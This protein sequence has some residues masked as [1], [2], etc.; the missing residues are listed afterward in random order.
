[1]GFRVLL[2]LIVA[3]TL[4]LGA[5]PASTQAQDA[6]PEATLDLPAW[7]QTW[8]ATQETEDIHAFTD[9]YTH[10]AT[11]EIIGDNVAVHDSLSIREVAGM[12]AAAVKD[13]DLVPTTFHAG[14]DWAV[15][16]YTM[17]F[18]A[19]LAGGKPVRDVR[20]VTVFDLDDAGLITRSTDYFN[21]LAI[22]TQLGRMLVDS[23]PTP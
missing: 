18:S 8:I 15:L 1:M 23:T 14:E 20:V 2:T 5:S 10:D 9:L 16:E 6:T 4:L 21:D 3:L 12:S 7:V 22:Q 17:S 13:L 19:M 11:Y